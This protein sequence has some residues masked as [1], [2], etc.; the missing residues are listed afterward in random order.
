MIIDYF[1]NESINEDIKNYI[2]RRIKTYGDLCYSYLV[3][4]KKTP[5]HPTIISNYPLDWVKK[6]KKNSYHLI[7]PVILTAKD[8]VA[9]FA[10][11]DNSVINKKS[12][13]S[14]VFKL[15][16]EY[17]IVNGYTFVLHDN[18]NNM[19]T[20]NIS[21][22]SDDSISF[23]ERIEINKEKIQ[24]LLII[25]HEKMLGLY[26]SNSDKNE[27]RNTQIERDIFSPRENEILYWAS[28]GKTYAEISI[29]LGIKRSTV[30]FHI[31]NV[32]RKLGVLNA[33]H[34]IR[35][36]IELKLIKPI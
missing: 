33:K 15:A 5:L 13:D 3:M 28:V 14:A 31:G 27:N 4:N 35:L 25:T 8:K 12:T 16:R 10:W 6:Y 11:D 34:A 19:A 32:V 9:P 7:D 22:G 18:S 17:N 36:G 26:Q 24:M 23:D 29:I 21:N 20:L 30:K 2:Q 1:D